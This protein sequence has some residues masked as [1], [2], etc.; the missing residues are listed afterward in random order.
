M[1]KYI[2]KAKIYSFYKKGT[3]YQIT[4]MMLDVPLKRVF[5][6]YEDFILNDAVSDSITKYNRYSDIMADSLKWM[7]SKASNSNF[8]LLTHNQH[9][10]NAYK[11]MING[12]RA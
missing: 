7:D 12:N 10:I 5:R 8:V 6:L 4:A 1:K 11:K 9:V 2:S 3:D